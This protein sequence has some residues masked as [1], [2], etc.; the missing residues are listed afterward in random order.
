MTT[1][2]TQQKPEISICIRYEYENNFIC[3]MLLFVWAFD[4]SRKNLKE[5]KRD[6]TTTYT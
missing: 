2:S 5:L 6:L 1:I 4:K 3:I